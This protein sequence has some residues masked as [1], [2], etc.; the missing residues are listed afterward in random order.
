M[1]KVTP[2]KKNIYNKRHLQ[3]F[4]EVQS[5][6]EIG[7]DVHEET[8]ELMQMCKC[9]KCDGEGGELVNAVTT[10]RL[11]IVPLL[12]EPTGRLHEQQPR[13]LLGY[14]YVTENDRTFQ[15]SLTMLLPELLSSCMS[16]FECI[17]SINID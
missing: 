4:H 6:I 16:S 1:T 14:I 13:I 2:L 5:S 7:W 15:Y 12:Y 17:G 10:N 3:Y 11:L 9:E 8:Q